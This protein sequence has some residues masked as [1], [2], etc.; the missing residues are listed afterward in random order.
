MDI[1]FLITWHNPLS[2]QELH[3]QGEDVISTW[4]SQ[5]VTEKTW[6]DTAR[7]SWEISPALAVYL[8]CR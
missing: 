8:P 6:R 4:R 7:L 1:E 3:F 5:P 2:L